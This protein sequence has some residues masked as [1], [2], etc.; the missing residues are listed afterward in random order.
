MWPGLQGS[1]LTLCPNP[2]VPSAALPC[3]GWAPHQLAT[4]RA[5]LP[6]GAAPASH[7]VGPT[8]S[9]AP[10]SPPPRGT[11]SALCF[12][13]QSQPAPGRYILM[14]TPPTL[15][16]PPMRCAREIPAPTPKRGYALSAGALCLLPTSTRDKL[17]ADL[18]LFVFSDIKV[19]WFLLPFCVCVPAMTNVFF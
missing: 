2:H 6:P 8:P 3:G 18:M 16:V 10:P 13:G 7:C 17:I 19:R 11:V 4:C 15:R 12:W 14:L 9:S 5:P 1:A